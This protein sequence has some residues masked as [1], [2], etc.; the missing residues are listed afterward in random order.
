MQVKVVDGGW[1]HTLAA[2]ADTLYAWGW[3]KFGQLGFAT[4]GDI[5]YPKAVPK[6]TSTITSITQI[7][8][9]WKHT[10]VVNSGGEMFAWG[11]G[12]NGQLGVPTS[13]DVYAP[14]PPSSPLVAWVLLCGADIRRA[15]PSL[16]RHACAVHAGLN[17][18]GLRYGAAG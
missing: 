2:T 16:A 13:A 5:N 6:M 18:T 17:V 1:R 15:W 11:R 7:A 14:L 10:V 3:N 9:G 4:D 8:C 12:T